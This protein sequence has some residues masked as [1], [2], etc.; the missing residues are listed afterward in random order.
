[1]SSHHQIEKIYDIVTDLPN[2]DEM[3]I[4]LQKIVIGY[5]SKYKSQKFDL[6]PHAIDRKNKLKRKDEWTKQLDDLFYLR[7]NKIINE[8]GHSWWATTIEE[9]VNVQIFF[10][11]LKQDFV[12]IDNESE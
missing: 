1:M 2:F 11:S 6:F 4:Y 8:K 9:M 5:L 10:D 3:R 7:M 12:T